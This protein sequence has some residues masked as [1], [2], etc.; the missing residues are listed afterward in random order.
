MNND[1]LYDRI[2]FKEFLFN[3]VSWS[4]FVLVNAIQL[5][6]L[7]IV[8]LFT[9]PF[10]KDRKIV[11]YFV[12]FFCRLFYILNFVQRNNFDFNNLKPPK[13]GERRI[14]ALNHASMFDVILMNSLPGPTK[15]IMKESYLKIPVIG[16]IALL[17]GT[18][19]LPEDNDGINRMSVYMKIMEKLERG[20]PI[21]IYPEGTKSKDGKIGKFY[22]GTFK[23]ALDTK[24][25]IVPVVFDTWNVI[26]PDKFWIRDVNVTIKVLDTIK[27]DTIKDMNYK[28]ISKMVRIKLLEGLIDV[29]DKRRQNKKYYRNKQKYIEIDNEMKAEL[30][31]LKENHE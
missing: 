10:D 14:Y 8:L 15:S 25:D 29:R 7:P 3:V 6:V 16:W 13:K 31:R 27:Y 26:R 18:I 22:H 21:V 28:E 23:L 2:T 4:M 1:N 17:T 11:S 12:K 24:A 9:L 20:T 30:L 5:V 19:I